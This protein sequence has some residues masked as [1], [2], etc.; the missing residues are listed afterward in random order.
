MTRWSGVRWYLSKVERKVKR[1]R[2]VWE[3]E[4]RVV[5]KWDKRP[6]ILGQMTPFYE[7]F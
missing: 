2:V 3:C 5:I 1:R 6:K 7:K 4:G